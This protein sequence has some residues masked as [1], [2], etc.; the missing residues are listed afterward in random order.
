MSNNKQIICGVVA[1]YNPFHEGHAYQIREARRKSGADIMIAVMSGNFVQRGEPAVIDKWKRAEAAVANGIDAVI[2]LPYVYAT[3]AATGFANGAVSILK[4]A[5]VSDI[6]F[7]SECGNLDNL[8]EIAETPVNPDHLRA[9]MDK[10]M[11]YPKAYSLLAGEMEPNDILAVSYLK[12]MQNTDITPVLVQRKGSYLDE[13]IKNYASALAIRKAIK[14]KRELHGS[15]PMDQVL[16][17]STPVWME[18]F[19]PYFRTFLL[20]SDPERLSEMFLYSEGIGNLMTHKAMQEETYE[21]FL[22]ACV[23]YRYTAGRI[24]RCML[25]GMLQLTKK[26]VNE[27]SP[28]H[29]LRILAF[30][31][32]GRK[33]LHDQRDSDIQIAS[34]FAAMPKDWRA[35]EYRS[36]LL[37][38]SVLPEKERNRILDRE[39]RGA[40]F[41]DQ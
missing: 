13:N 32:T 14:E 7:G 8:K 5:G 18:S 2:E 31:Q 9:C 10:G 20:T 6:C 21:G 24:R 23:N 25:Q 35:L 11:S 27:L 15:T 28:L 30:N 19:Y 26:E 41:I 36:T 37:Y 12:A 29:T 34:R 33:W 38:T 4:M 17:D 40:Q 3:Q 22:K 1:E 39:I 16:N